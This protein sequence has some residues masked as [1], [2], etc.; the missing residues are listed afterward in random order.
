MTKLNATEH[1]YLRTLGWLVGVTGI[2]ASDA[3]ANR[4]MEDHPQ[5]GVIAVIGGYIFTAD[6][7]DLGQ[8]PPC[9]DRCR[10]LA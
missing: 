7:D 10:K 8:H 6:V 3:A 2:F 1:L 9:Q 5:D 4:H